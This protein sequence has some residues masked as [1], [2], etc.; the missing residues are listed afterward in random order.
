[1][2]PAP[3]L[4]I[5]GSAAFFSLHYVLALS[6]L[7]PH[8]AVGVCSEGVFAGGTIWSLLVPRFGSLWPGYLSHAVV[9]LCIFGLGAWLAFG[10]EGA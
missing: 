6:I 7:L 1:L 3:P 2:R 5:F 10:G 9:D 8:T 4:A